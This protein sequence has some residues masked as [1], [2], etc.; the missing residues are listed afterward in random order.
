MNSHESNDGPLAALQP[1]NGRNPISRPNIQQTHIIPETSQKLSNYY[2]YKKNI[3][4]QLLT[5]L[6]ITI[7]YHCTYITFLTAE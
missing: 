2:V 4:N 3:I 6:K 5:G 7:L 1:I